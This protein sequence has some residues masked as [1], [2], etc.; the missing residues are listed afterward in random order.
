MI[1]RLRRFFSIGDPRWGRGP[2]SQDN[3]TNDSSGRPNGQ[4]PSD[5][6][7]KDADNGRGSPQS[8]PGQCN[9]QG[10]R[11]PNDGPPDLD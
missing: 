1:H 10:S 5:T 8:P 4:G 6:D 11:R 3:D 7:P 9:R 2:D